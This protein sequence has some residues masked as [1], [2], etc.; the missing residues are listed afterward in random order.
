ML[1]D[2]SN[3]HPGSSY[4]ASRQSWNLRSCALV[5]AAYLLQVVKWSGA[6][7]G[8]QD[9]PSTWGLLTRALWGFIT[10]AKTDHKNPANVI[11]PE[12]LLTITS[13]ICS[14]L[15]C[16]VFPSEI[17]MLSLCIKCSLLKGGVSLIGQGTPQWLSRLELRAS[18]NV[19][20]YFYISN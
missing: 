18:G 16:M 4:T 12:D 8:S 5:A 14:R 19:M 20:S 6:F 17:L 1:L 3:H 2:R 9:W 11:S 7:L 10:P 13:I 15:L